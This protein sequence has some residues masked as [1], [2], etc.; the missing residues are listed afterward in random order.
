MQKIIFN[1]QNQIKLTLFFFTNIAVKNFQ[2]IYNELSRVID[3]SYFSYAI[4]TV[5][6]KR[7]HYYSREDWQEAFIKDRLILDC[8][9][10]KFARQSK[11]T[12]LSW[13]SLS[14]S[15]SKKERRVMSARESF[16][17]GNGV[18]IRQTLPGGLIE[19]STLAS[20][21]DN[22]EFP[23]KFMKNKDIIKEN[24]RHIRTIALSSL[25]IQ[26]LLSYDA[27]SLLINLLNTSMP[28]SHILQ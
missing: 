22:Y 14:S 28:T 15:L 3:C 9:L 8:P 17:I 4:E 12:M 21:R 5:D 10:L 6:N 20:Y 19:M 7:V 26:G 23:Q 11:V 18:G 2:E 1:T 16:D 27:F 13:S 24:I 25:A